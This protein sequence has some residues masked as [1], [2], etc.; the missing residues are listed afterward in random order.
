MIFTCG[1]SVQ[2]KAKPKKKK[3]KSL[4][5][6]YPRSTFPML[7]SCRWALVSSRIA[8]FPGIHPSLKPFV[9]DGLS[10]FTT[11]HALP[12]RGRE[13]KKGGRGDKSTNEFAFH[14]F[15]ALIPKRERKEKKYEE[16]ERRERKERKEGEEAKGGERKQKGEK[17]RLNAACQRE[18]H[19]RVCNNFA[20][21]RRSGRTP[22]SNA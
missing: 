2:S 6:P 10:R 4:P 21:F 19:A 18:C 13:K 17:N 20:V 8:V 5:R 9:N 3:K 16:K 22:P 15:T 14:F 12:K 1:M 7:S 11:H